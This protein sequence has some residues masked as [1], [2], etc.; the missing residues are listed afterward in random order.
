MDFILK[1]MLEKA[2]EESSN[3]SPIEQIKQTLNYQQQIL[4]AHQTAI[5]RLLL[6]VVFICFTFAFYVI[7]NEIRFYRFRKKVRN[8]VLS[9]EHGT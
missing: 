3:L 4:D 1:E 9:V 7:Y 5:E 8:E 2:F 6:F